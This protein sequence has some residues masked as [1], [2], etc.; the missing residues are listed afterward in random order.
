MEIRLAYKNEFVP[1]FNSIVQSFKPAEFKS[2]RRSTVPLL[3]YW[4]DYLKKSQELFKFLNIETTSHFTACF[5]YKVPV[6]LGNPAF[7]HQ[8]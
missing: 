1:D 6:Q 3:L 7:S 5:E 4:K 2:P 8:S